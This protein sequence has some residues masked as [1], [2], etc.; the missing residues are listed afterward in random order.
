VSLPIGRVGEFRARLNE[1]AAAR[2]KSADFRAHIELDAA[3]ELREVTR[4]ERG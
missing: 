3:L 1:Y 2:L 4:R